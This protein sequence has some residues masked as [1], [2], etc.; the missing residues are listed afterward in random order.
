MIS[1]ISIVKET[2][3]F[4]KNAYSGWFSLDNIFISP[5]GLIKVYVFPLAE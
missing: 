3:E 2:K 1:L 4:F 5:E